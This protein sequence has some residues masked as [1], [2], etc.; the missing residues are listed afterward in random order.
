MP[1]LAQLAHLPAPENTDGISFAPALLGMKKPPL[2]EFLYWEFTSSGGMQAI[3]SGQWK[4]IRRNV[5]EN[6]LK[7][8]EL[9][10]LSADPGEKI[11][12]ADQHPE[13][14]LK[15]KEYA[16]KRIPSPRPEW[17]FIRN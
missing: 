4:A 13:V 17:N 15:M 7:K 10:D 11:N 3:R 6:P 1:T 9:Y 14:I 16:G 5:K 12:I 8:F 2:H